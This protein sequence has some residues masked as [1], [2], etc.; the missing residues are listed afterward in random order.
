MMLWKK[1]WQINGKTSEMGGM[2][3]MGRTKSLASLNDC[4]DATYRVINTPLYSAGESSSYKK[5]LVRVT[6]EDLEMALEILCREDMHSK[7]QEMIQE[8]LNIRQRPE[9]ITVKGAWAD[10]F[11]RA[12]EGVRMAAKRRRCR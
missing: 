3:Q 4:T 8:E 12:W 2:R 10:S 9:R 11:R 1:N 6:D 7:K 5:L